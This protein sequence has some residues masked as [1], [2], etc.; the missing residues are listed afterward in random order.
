MTEL[1]LPLSTATLVT[2]AWVFARLAGLCLFVPVIGGLGLTVR[3]RL[4]LALLITILLLPT[5]A[6]QSTGAIPSVL[7]LVLIAAAEFGCG[8][9]LA[10]A[11]QLVI[12]GFQLAGQYIGQVAG[13]DWAQVIDP[14]SGQET[15]G[16][17][18]FVERF[19]LAMFL[20]LGG[21]R[22]L[23]SAVL[24][25]FR[26]L[27]VAGI[28]DRLASLGAV[29]AL[30]GNTFALA[31]RISAPVVA[32]VLL[33]IWLLAILSR[34]LPQGNWLASGISIQTVVAL[35][36]L[37]GVLIV[38]GPLVESEVAAAITAVLRPV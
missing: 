20:I 29:I 12:A 14:A 27:P 37:Y 31:L 19:T 28:E 17:A 36:V 21:H 5:I 15:S 24:D 6:A 8:C 10:A 38:A 22:Q 30:A 13:L 35:I 9:L 34:S 18:V 3:M 16:L 26:M 25:S 11:V 33:A 1:P 32:A 7:G 23:L 2:F 4:G